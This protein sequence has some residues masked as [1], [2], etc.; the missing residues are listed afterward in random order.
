MVT[1]DLFHSKILLSCLYIAPNS[2]DTYQSAVLSS[3]MALTSGDIP[4]LI[5]G[6]FNTPDICWSTLSA[7]SPFSRSLC[8][9]VFSQNLKQFVFC[10][11]HTHGNILDLVLSNTEELIGDLQVESDIC[12]NY[13]DH[14]LISFPLFISCSIR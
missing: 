10:S 3:L 1:V 11:T 5:T 13:S 2:S 8:D 4:V 14:Y 9:L 12:L 7:T 6:D